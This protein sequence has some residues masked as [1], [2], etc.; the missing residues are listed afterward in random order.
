MTSN[1]K[2]QLKQS[3]PC[4]LTLTEMFSA[5]QTNASPF[6]YFLSGYSLSVST[7]RKIVEKTYRVCCDK[8]AN[9]VAFFYDGQWHNLT[10]KGKDGELEP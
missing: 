8:A 10:T 2:E 1:V 4:S 6:C 5:N 9:I 7:M 3:P